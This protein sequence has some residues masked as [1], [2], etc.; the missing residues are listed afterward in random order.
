LK[1]IIN[2]RYPA[3]NE[4][5]YRQKIKKEMGVKE[6]KPNWPPPVFAG[7]GSPLYSRETC[8]ATCGN[9]GDA[10]AIPGGF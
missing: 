1:A 2:S 6:V 5:Y 8:P 7:P 3:A 9:A 10:A 4:Y